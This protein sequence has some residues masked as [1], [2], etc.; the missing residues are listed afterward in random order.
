MSE[1]Q[2]VFIY[3]DKHRQIRKKIKIEPSTIIYNNL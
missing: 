2:Y 1:Q 3:N